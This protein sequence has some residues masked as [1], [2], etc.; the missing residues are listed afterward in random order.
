[1]KKIAIQMIDVA[2]SIQSKM[3]TSLNVIQDDRT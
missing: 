1:L 2:A 3:Y